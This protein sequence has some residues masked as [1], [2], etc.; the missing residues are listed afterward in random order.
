MGQIQ[1]YAPGP[2]SLA[3]R[4]VGT[5][6]INQKA[7]SEY[8]TLARGAGQVRDE[9]VANQKEFAK[10]LFDNISNIAYAVGTKAGHMMAQQKQLSAAT[11]KMNNGIKIDNIVGDFSKATLAIQDHIKQQFSSDPGKAQQAIDDA[12]Q[13]NIR[14]DDGLP[15]FNNSQGAQQD[16]KSI[17]SAASKDPD[18]RAQPQALA[19]LSGKLQ[20]IRTSVNEKTNSW[21]AGQRVDNSLAL[22]NKTSRDLSTYASS[23]DGTPEQHLANF[24]AQKD[25]AL[26]TITSENS[27][28]ALGPNVVADK[29]FKAHTEASANYILG[30]IEN[31]TAYNKDP[32]KQLAELDQLEKQLDNHQTNG[33]L[34][35]EKSA[36][37]LKGQI[38]TASGAADKVLTEQA[39]SKLLDFKLSIVNNQFKLAE[40]SSDV[41]FVKQTMQWAHDNLLVAD[42]NIKD[43]QGS[44]NLP[45]KA[46]N[47]LINLQL[48]MIDDI[49]QLVTQGQGHIEHAATK[50]Q[51]QQNELR[52]DAR[53]AQAEARHLS[54]EER[55]A[56]SEAKAA[57]HEAKAE[58]NRQLQNKLTMMQL[59]VSMLDPHNDKDRKEMASLSDEL[60]SLAIQGGKDSTLTAAQMNK[61]AA[62]AVKIVGANSAIKTDPGLFGMNPTIKR[63]NPNAAKDSKEAM[64][65]RQKA[66]EGMQQRNPMSFLIRAHP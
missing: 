19:E 39:K 44:S 63:L 43:L 56:A 36:L 30:G 13:N 40:N 21:I 58:A 24:N 28:R 2:G 31:A 18:F 51:Q 62:P 22:S 1:P 66:I 37:Q 34:F 25:V 42:R 41:P 49:K 10:G 54:V 7:G 3:N 26:A 38:E 11:L 14:N 61:Y 53:A 4:L 23:L 27:L 5:P 48:G 33:L 50:A 60:A 65:L 35:G 16:M 8:E 29:A 6:G 15:M 64:Q 57:E 20:G 59:R 55:R 32:V 52:R 47:T 46:K 45:Q 17:M 9:V 12:L